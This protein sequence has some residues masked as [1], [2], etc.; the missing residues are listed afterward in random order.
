MSNF[1]LDIIFFQF[2]VYITN[3]KQYMYI[4]NSYP[5]NK[6]VANRDGLHQ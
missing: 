6:M 4:P 1:L 2:S 5:G 3:I